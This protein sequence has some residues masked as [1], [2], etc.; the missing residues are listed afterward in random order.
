MGW[1][2]TPSKSL[3]LNCSVTLVSMPVKASRTA[4]CVGQV[5]A[6]AADVRLVRDGMADELDHDRVADVVCGRDGLLDG[7]RHAGLGDGDAVGVEQ[8][9][10]LGLGEGGPALG[11]GLLR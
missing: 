10:G 7:G 11:S 9:L 4:V 1:T 2:E 3:A 6:N 5:E 8:L